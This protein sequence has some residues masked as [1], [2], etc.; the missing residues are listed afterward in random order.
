MSIFFIVFLLKIIIA[1]KSIFD[2]LND[3]QIIT[4]NETNFDAYMQ[5]NAEYKWF[6]MFYSAWCPHCQK[7]LP[8]LQELSQN[9]TQEHIKFALIDWY[10][11]F[12]RK[13]L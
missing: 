2:D 3:T 12:S 4:L 6:I 10:L 1:Q 7:M 11:F 8:I 5:K 13:F 9:L